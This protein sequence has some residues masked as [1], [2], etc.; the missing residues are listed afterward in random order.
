MECGSITNGSTLKSDSS[1]LHQREIADITFDCESTIEITAAKANDNGC[2][3]TGDTA[4]KGDLY[5][6]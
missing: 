2:R 5:H 1:I 3:P 4:D 6:V